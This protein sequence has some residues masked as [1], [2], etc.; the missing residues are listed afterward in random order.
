MSQLV[1]NEFRDLCQILVR[2]WYA[3]PGRAIGRTSAR[4]TSLV[5][6]ALGECVSVSQGAYQDLAKITEA[7]TEVTGHEPPSLQEYRKQQKERDWESAPAVMFRITRGDEDVWDQPVTLNFFL[8]LSGAFAVAVE[9][10]FVVAE[11]AGSLTVDYLLVKPY[12]ADLSS[13][14]TIPPIYHLLVCVNKYHEYQLLTKIVVC[15]TNLPTIVLF[16]LHPA[17]APCSTPHIPAAPPQTPST[18]RLISLPPTLH[19]PLH[20]LP[21]SCPPLPSTFPTQFFQY[22]RSWDSFS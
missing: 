9:F 19:P 2:G 7:W 1:G 12:N 21:R 3:A 18:A 20:V 4:A 15:A 6:R 10:P 5:A 22:T 14:P 17:L 13:D 16:S 8:G 11:I